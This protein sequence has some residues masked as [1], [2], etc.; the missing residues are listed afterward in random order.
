MF[1]D[2]HGLFDDYGGVVLDQT[3]GDRIAAALRGRKALILQ[4][5]GLLTAGRSIE[6]T[7]FWYL[8]LERAAH[9]QIVAEALGK[10]RII[11]AEVAAQTA[12]KIGRAHVWTPVTNAQL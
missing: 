3:E 10:P 9:G 4:N 11:P 5:H 1:H 8:A 2:D 12:R 6:A 7:A